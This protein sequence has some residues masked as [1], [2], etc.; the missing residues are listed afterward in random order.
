MYFHCTICKCNENKPRIWGKI[1]I[2]SVATFLSILRQAR[3]S[4][5]SNVKNNKNKYNII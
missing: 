2:G 3:E 1:Q 5:Q 4:G